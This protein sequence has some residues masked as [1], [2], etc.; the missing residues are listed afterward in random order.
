MI[1]TMRRKFQDGVNEKML[2]RLFHKVPKVY[3]EG[4]RRRVFLR[5]MN[6]D[7]LELAGSRRPTPNHSRELGLANRKRAS[8]T[9]HLAPGAILGNVVHDGEQSCGIIKGIG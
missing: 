6:R 3:S 1:M 7:D 9:P 4:R 8:I 2:S 5:P